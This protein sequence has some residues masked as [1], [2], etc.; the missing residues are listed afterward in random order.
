MRKVRNTA[1]RKN[2]EAIDAISRALSQYPQRRGWVERFRAAL[3]MSIADLAGKAQLDPSVISRAERR[4]KDGNI[5]IKQV[6][7]IADAMGGKLVYAIIPREGRIED[8]IMEQARKK[9]KRVVMRTRAHM[10]LEAQS[11]G[12]QSQNDAIEELAHEM[13]REIGRGFWR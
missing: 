8:L 7:K 3:G 11:E 6:E 2:S 9:A 1:R 10:T 13:A 4:E 5:T 12:L